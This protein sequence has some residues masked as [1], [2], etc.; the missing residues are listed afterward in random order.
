MELDLLIPGNMLIGGNSTIQTVN[1]THSTVLVG[2]PG[3]LGNANGT[4]KNVRSNGAY[5]LQIDNETVLYADHGNHCIRKLTR[6]GNSVSDYVGNCGTAR[7]DRKRR[8][9]TA[10]GVLL[11]PISLV[12][13]TSEYAGPQAGAVASLVVENSSRL[14][15]GRI[16]SSTFG[17]FQVDQVVVQES[18]SSGS[19]FHVNA[20][21]GT[22]SEISS[23][24]GI[25]SI[26]A[27]S[28]Y[29]DTLLV[30]D[31]LLITKLHVTSQTKLDIV[32]HNNS[33]YAEGT[34]SEAKFGS[35]TDIVA[36]QKDLY[37]VADEGNNVL[38]IVD[39]NADTVSSICVPS[40]DSIVDG[41]PSECR[42]KG[43]KRLVYSDGVLYI[44]DHEGSI[45]TLTG[46]ADLVLYVHVIVN[47]MHFGICKGFVDTF[48][49]GTQLIIF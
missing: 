13:F 17:S 46:I 21:T 3:E 31:D 20:S 32:R 29:S 41:P 15:L 7:G 33:G 27:S 38:R 44:S 24:S 6:S 45:R 4:G 9:V 47:R 22:V 40:G 2:K 37:I 34:V 16:Q 23:E 1:Q 8:D 43:P 12:S 35:V 18:E 11:N 28:Y 14:E 19:I 39:V 42:F 26:R 36:V 48:S 5:I 10:A 30:T 25:N 49:L